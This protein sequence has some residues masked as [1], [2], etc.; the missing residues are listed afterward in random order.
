L[1]IFYPKES[2]QDILHLLDGNKNRTL[3]LTKHQ[4][5][6]LNIDF[7]YVQQQIKKW[8]YINQ[9]KI[10][11]VFIRH[12]R[13]VEQFC[14]LV[15]DQLTEK[16]PTRKFYQSMRILRQHDLIKVFYLDK[17]DDL[18]RD[19]NKILHNAG[20]FLNKDRTLLL[21]RN[22]TIALNKILKSMKSAR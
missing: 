1:F 22:S 7:Q 21:I 2:K 15:C 10:Q 9:D 4:L 8:R 17:L 6:G 20:Q 5:H 16:D 14:M 13:F 19:R 12:F 18:A 11:L 3:K